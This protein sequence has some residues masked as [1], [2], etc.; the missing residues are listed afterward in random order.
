MLPLET[1]SE[2]SEPSSYRTNPVVQ[3]LSTRTL[4]G[5]CDTEPAAGSQAPDAADASGIATLRVLFRH[6]AASAPDAQA[7]PP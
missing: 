1:R 4:I 2:G 5:S 7:G 3:A 6:A